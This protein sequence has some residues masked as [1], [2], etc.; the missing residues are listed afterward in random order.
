MAGGREGRW[1]VVGDEGWD[2]QSPVGRQGCG[3][4]CGL[5]MEETGEP[6]EDIKQSYKFSFQHFLLFNLTTQQT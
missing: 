3:E 2:R 5:Y 1:Q 4:P 6:L